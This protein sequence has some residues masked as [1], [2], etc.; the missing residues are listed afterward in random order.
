MFVF[1]GHASVR[2]LIGTL[3]YSVELL[4]LLVVKETESV[5]GKCLTSVCHFWL[6]F[7]FS[8]T[9]RSVLFRVLIMLFFSIILN[10]LYLFIVVQ[11][12]LH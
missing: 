2:P 3:H 11:L 4:A 1:T 7:R 12:L 9:N 6:L 5:S 10:N 8:F